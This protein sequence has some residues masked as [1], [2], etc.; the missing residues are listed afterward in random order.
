[1]KNYKWFSEARFGA[2]IHWG[3][4][5]IPG[6]FWNGREMDYIGEWIQSYFRIPNVDYSKLASKF[7]PVEFDAEKIISHFHSAGIRYIVFTAKHH[8]GFS[9]Y[10]SKISQYNIFDATPFK[11]DPLAELAEACRR[12]GIKLGIYYSHCLDWYEKNGGDPGPDV[13][14][15]KGMSWGNDWDFPEYERKNFDVYFNQKVIPQ[16]TELLTNYGEVSILW[17]DCPIVIEKRHALA[18]R[19]LV[20]QYQPDCLINGRIGCNMQDYESLGD[21]MLPVSSSEML[22]EAA[23]TLNDTWG[24]K[25]GDNNW[26]SFAEIRDS[27]IDLSARGANYLLNFGPDAQGQ[28]PKPSVKILEQLAEWMKSSE[29]AIHSVTKNPFPQELPWCRCT[30]AENKLNIFTIKRQERYILCGIHGKILSCTIPYQ[31]QE[32]RLE[33]YP[34]EEIIYGR[35]PITV[36]FE[37]FF[38]RELFAIGGE[39]VLVPGN[40]ELHHGVSGFS[41]SAAEPNI[42]GVAAE[43]LKI[44]EHSMLESSGSL[45]NW[46]NPTD[47]ISW[48]IR[49][50]QAG[51][52]QISLVSRTR[53][54]GNEWVGDREVVVEFNDKKIQAFLQKDSMVTQDCY[55]AA[56]SRLG[57]LKVSDGEAGKLILRTLQITSLR[58]VDMEF[59]KLHLERLNS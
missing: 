58:A 48:N 1:M 45:S 5:A 56:K 9:M 12:H 4:Y 55:P 39:L 30:F 37:P 49:F 38:S 17:L 34:S 47:F 40:G 18:I 21:N 22:I 23:A 24:Y 19:S 8:D 54:H 46:H 32:D 3:L 33:L 31:H 26:K 44:S 7:N 51:I 43:I 10:H 42:R 6:G 53:Y 2:F 52:Y 57:V 27:I 50:P 59:T 25:S 29:S 13:G 16:L 11:R 35:I 15:N 20:D 41:I 14:K 28:L 36:E